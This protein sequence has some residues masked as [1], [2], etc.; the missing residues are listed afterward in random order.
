MRLRKATLAALVA[1]GAAVALAIVFGAG[2]KTEHAAAA[3]EAVPGEPTVSIVSPRNG[4]V[5]ANHAVVV[6]VDLENFQLAPLHFG[7]EPELG[8]GSIRFSLN[9]VPNCVDPQKLQKAIDSPLGNG[10]LVGASM[11]Y[12][13]FS[14]PN[15]ILAEEIGTAG[16]YSPATRPEI[17][18][19]GLPPGF[20]RLT[21]TLAQNNG[22]TTPYHAVTNF[23]ILQKPG[24]HQKK[25][26][27]GKV[28]SAKAAEKLE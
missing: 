2:E 28:S 21:V 15:G 9:R 7:K 4:E 24:H 18:Y 16:S 12:P 1:T 19:R 23:Q 11:D 13:K 17:F 27:P 26:A 22:A 10:R 20:Y 6:K 14:G 3:T 25:C 5:Q 8:E